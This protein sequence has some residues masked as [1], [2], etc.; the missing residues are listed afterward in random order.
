LVNGWNWICVNIFSVWG[1]FRLSHSSAQNQSQKVAGRAA[2]SAERAVMF[3]SK[4][5]LNLSF[6]FICS[7]TEQLPK[8]PVGIYGCINGIGESDRRGLRAL[9]YV[10][11]FFWRGRFNYVVISDS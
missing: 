11:H 3:S 10:R 9:M 6:R 4:L 5:C 7:Q 8:Q 2:G 1:G